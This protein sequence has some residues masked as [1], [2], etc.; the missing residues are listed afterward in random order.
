MTFSQ[1]YSRAYAEEFH[2]FIDGSNGMNFGLEAWMYISREIKGL[3]K[4]AHALGTSQPP[5]R[6]AH[7]SNAVTAC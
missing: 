4:E 7:Q 6:A 1:R 3:I 2:E 5:G